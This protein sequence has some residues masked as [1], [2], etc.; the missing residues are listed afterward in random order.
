MMYLMGR[1]TAR[2]FFYASKNYYESVSQAF[3][4]PYDQWITIQ[5]TLEQFN[6]YTIIIAD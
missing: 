6:G 1:N 5:M 4:L 3:F 2:F